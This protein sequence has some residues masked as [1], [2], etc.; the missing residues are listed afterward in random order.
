MRVLIVRLSSLGDLVHAMPA[1][2]DIRRAR[3]DARIDWV[4]E[5]AFVPLLRCF[6]GVCRIV[7]FALRRWRR[8]LAASRLEIAG[9]WCRLRAERYDAVLDLQGLLKSAAVT[10]LAAL[11]PGGMRYGL[12]NRTDGA[13]YEPLARCAY[14]RALA[15]PARIHVVDRSRELAS[16]AL[17]YA[18]QGA[19][20]TLWQVPPLTA[21]DAVWA[22][23]RGVLLIHGSAKAQK[24]LTAGYWVGL[25]CALLRQGARVLLP[26]GSAAERERAELIAAG[27]AA[28]SA[29][30]GPLA[31]PANGSPDVAAAVGGPPVGGAA[32]RVLPRLPLDRLAAVMV[33]LQGSIGLDTGLSHMS[34]TLGRPTVQLFIEDKAW[35]AG[36]YWAPR[37]LVVQADAATPLTVEQ[38]LAAWQRVA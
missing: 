25:G 32:V 8:S 9:F 19:P 10:R 16:R 23:A 30:A 1:L 2:A 34:A 4:A 5:E 12:A 35:R 21:E 22:D 27:I 3:P 33:R 37:T 11:A 15:M 38:A 20:R 31:G 6:D 13:A 17:G 24:L 36:A 29:A 7:P 28:G 18:V 14:G 26:W